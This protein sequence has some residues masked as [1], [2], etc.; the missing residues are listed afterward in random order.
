MIGILWQ[1]RIAL[2]GNILYTLTCPLFLNHAKKKIS[3][4]KNAATDGRIQ[5]QSVPRKWQTCRSITWDTSVER[6]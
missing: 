1:L 5:K 6:V 2:K 3:S 4:P